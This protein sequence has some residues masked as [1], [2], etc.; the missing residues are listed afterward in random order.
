[1]SDGDNEN[2]MTDDE[3]KAADV[4][5]RQLAHERISEDLNAVIN[6]P[7]PLTEADYAIVRDSLGLFGKAQYNL[8]TGKV[9]VP[10]SVW[11]YLT[12]EQRD[13][14]MQAWQSV[15]DTV[16]PFKRVALGLVDIDVLDTTKR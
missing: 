9:D 12:T 5:R 7:K 14:A 16:P 11:E 13:L 3:R 4:R 10:V 1:M 2:W 15:L 8:T 6:G